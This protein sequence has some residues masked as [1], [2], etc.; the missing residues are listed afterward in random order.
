MQRKDKASRAEYD[1]QRYL[2]KAEELKEKQRAYN[3]LAKE[4]RKEYY[5]RNKEKIVENIRKKK[6]ILV[7]ALGGICTICGLAYPP[8]VFD[9]HLVNPDE[10]DFSIRDGKG[11]KKSLDE[12]KKCILLCANCHRVVHS[13]L[14]H[15]LFG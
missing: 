15:D 10:K 9:F 8:E 14:E 5:S 6:D 2:D 3:L 1:K 7:A 11:I 12:I 4:Y 13:K